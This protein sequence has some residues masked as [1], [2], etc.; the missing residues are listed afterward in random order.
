MLMQLLNFEGFMEGASS[1]AP[2]RFYGAFSPSD[3]TASSPSH[4]TAS[5]PSDSTDTAADSTDGPSKF[6]ADL[7]SRGFFSSAVVSSNPGE[8]PVY[9]CD[10]DTSPPDDQIIKTNQTHILVRSLMLKNQKDDSGSND[11]KVAPVNQVSRKRPAEKPLDKA[12]GKKPMSRAQLDALPDLAYSRR[13]ERKPR[14]FFPP[15]M[16]FGGIIPWPL[17]KLTDF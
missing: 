10:H 7:P 9:I 3:S 11:A 13:R 17:D 5:S 12:E 16:R 14:P 4:S 6:L 1:S 8:M 2:P 15:I